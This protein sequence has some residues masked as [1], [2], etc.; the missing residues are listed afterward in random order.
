MHRL[1]PVI[2][3]AAC[4]GEGT[5][6]LTTWGEDYIEVGIP[7]EDFADGCSVTYSE[8]LVT[9]SGRALVDGNGD[10]AGEVSGAQVYDL[11]PAGP[12]EMGATEV[13]ADHYDRVDATIAPSAGATGG[14][15]TEAQVAALV[16]AQGSIRAVGTVTCGADT[17]AFDWVFDT[18]TTYAC[19]P[20]DLTIPAGGD[21]ATELTIHGDHLFYDGLEDPDAVVR[22]EAVVAADADAD[23]VVTL[24][25]LSAVSVAALGYDVGRYSDVTDLAAFV[26]FLSRTLGHVDGEGHCQVD[27]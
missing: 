26:E 18:D 3:L 5:W 27:L 7:A 6:T 1:F 21:D 10:V 9:F 16:A 2:L 24:A 19:E 8:F 14:N 12:H 23:D 17:V 4:G 11:V 25:E 13:R 20:E 22:G 15:V